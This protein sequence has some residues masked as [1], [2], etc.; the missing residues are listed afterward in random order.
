MQRR[1]KKERLERKGMIWKKQKGGRESY[2]KVEKKVQEEKG[3]A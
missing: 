3:R 2:E 1:K